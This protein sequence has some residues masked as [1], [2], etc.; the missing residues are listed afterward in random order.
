MNDWPAEEDARVQQLSAAQIN[1]RQLLE[2]VDDEQLPA[3]D[4]ASLRRAP[5]IPPSNPRPP[6]DHVDISDGD[7]AEDVDHPDAKTA[8]E[9]A[10]RKE[11]LGFARR[12]Q[13]GLKRAWKGGVGALGNAV[14]R[15]GAAGAQDSYTAGKVL[16]GIGGA[17]K[18]VIDTTKDLSKIGQGVDFAAGLKGENS[19]LEQNI[20]GLGFNMNTIAKAEF[21]PGVKVADTAKA[22]LQDGGTLLEVAGRGITAASGRKALDF[23][24]DQRRKYMEQRDAFTSARDDMRTKLRGGEQW[25]WQIRVSGRCAANPGRAQSGQC[26]QRIRHSAGV[27][28]LHGGNG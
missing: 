15:I 21:A 13:G 6:S 7:K 22:A 20:P 25:R 2:G 26:G 3:D 24:D 11:E 28:V 14:T 4:D 12:E 23:G 27:R 10:K 19:I 18:G 8:R 1:N 9:W 16:G 17:A 5:D